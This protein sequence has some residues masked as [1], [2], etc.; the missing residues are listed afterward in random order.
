MS[1]FITGI[2]S[3]SGR[4]ISTFGEGLCRKFGL[5]SELNVV[6]NP[7]TTYHHLKAAT[8]GGRGAELR[9]MRYWSHHHQ[10]GLWVTYVERHLEVL[11][12]HS[13]SNV[14]LWAEIVSV[15]YNGNN[16]HPWVD[17]LIISFGVFACVVSDSRLDKNVEVDHKLGNM[18]HLK[19]LHVP[20]SSS[21]VFSCD[22]AWC[23]FTA[24]VAWSG[25]STSTEEN[26]SIWCSRSCCGVSPSAC[27][28]VIVVLWQSFLLL[29]PVGML[30]L[31][32]LI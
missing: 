26:G 30:F 22:F 7:K 11:I 20:L 10:C 29:L 6:Y 4:L 18:Y 5:M 1:A 9:W 15:F 2:I 28:K 31:I 8:I 27:L 3:P 14:N 23:Q 17:D 16:S 25:I 12:F 13:V 21:T 19:C 32:L 24:H